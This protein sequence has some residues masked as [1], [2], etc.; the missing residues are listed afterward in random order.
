MK[1]LYILL[2][3]F[4]FIPS[5]SVNAA[6]TPPASYDYSFAYNTTDGEFQFSDGTDTYT[7][8]FTR[9][10]DGVYWNYTWTGDA[11]GLLPFE[12]TLTFNRSNT[13][14][15]LGTTG[16]IATDTKIGSDNTVGTVPG[17]KI[18]LKYNNNYTNDYQSFI[19][20]S[21]NASNFVFQFNIN[22]LIYI[23]NR[24]GPFFVVSDTQF[25]INSF[26]PSFSNVEFFRSNLSAALYLDAFY[27]KDL[28]QSAAYTAGVESTTAFQEGYEEGYGFG[29]QAGVEEDNAYSLGYAKGLQE[30]QDM[31]TGSSIIVLVLALMAFAM[32]L[33][34][35]TSKRRIFN[36]FASGLFIALGA[37]LFEYPAFIIV[38]IGLVIVNV[39]YTFVSD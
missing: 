18:Y 15:T 4:F 7:P 33:F 35:F 11:D 27:L 16:Y 21:S 19:D 38:T 32:M 6:L 17:P 8:E 14:W 1:K 26:V 31:E 20:V 30:G 29:Y 28:G 37:I 34:G 9:T 23:T 24:S 5:L 22:T 13:S 3:A 12:V 2:L 39:Y 36:L 10:A 25:L